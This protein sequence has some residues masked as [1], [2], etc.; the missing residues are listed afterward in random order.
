MN[1]EEY[2]TYEI[3]VVNKRQKKKKVRDNFLSVLQQS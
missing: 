1:K 2:Y 3:M